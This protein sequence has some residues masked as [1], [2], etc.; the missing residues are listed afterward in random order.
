MLHIDLHF[1]VLQIEQST[2][3][4]MCSVLIAPILENVLTVTSYLLHYYVNMTCDRDANQPDISQ[5]GVVYVNEKL[6]NSI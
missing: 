2:L 5:H 4:T 6:N 3:S 1:N